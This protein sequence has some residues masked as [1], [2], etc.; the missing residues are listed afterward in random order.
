MAPLPRRLKI[1]FVLCDSRSLTLYRAQRG[2]AISESRNLSAIL[3]Q[4]VRKQ[5]M[6]RSLG[7]TPR[8]AESRLVVLA[9]I[10]PLILQGFSEEG[11]LP[12][13]KRFAQTE[14]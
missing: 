10:I 4:G 8:L 13:N 12:K 6:A 1:D 9:E 14:R 3:P 11:L 5:K 2:P 7:H